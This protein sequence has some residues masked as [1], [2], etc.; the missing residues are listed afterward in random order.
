MAPA[1][2]SRGWCC[3]VILVLVLLLGVVGAVL[4]NKYLNDKEPPT[5]QVVESSESSEDST[6]YKVPK[7]DPKKRK[8]EKKKPPKKPKKETR[9]G[10]LRHGYT[11]YGAGTESVNG[12]YYSD[13]QPD[14]PGRNPEYTP[15]RYYKDDGKG[16]ITHELQRKGFVL[17][18]CTLH[19]P[20]GRYDE[21]WRIMDNY[22]VMDVEAKKS[23]P[24]D[25]SDGVWYTM[26]STELTQSSNGNVTVF[27]KNKVRPPLVLG[28]PIKAGVLREKSRRRGGA[29]LKPDVRFVVEV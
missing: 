24:R 14:T 6:D 22:Y 15:A 11:V 1:K 10:K 27:P 20:D 21:R 16:V 13:I 19:L 5:S 4:V 12:F 7:P 18:K 2:S 23:P 3:C 25:I 9:K 26:K 29:M 28:L 8:D 17:K